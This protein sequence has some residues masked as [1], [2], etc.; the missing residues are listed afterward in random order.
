MLKGGDFESC[1][2]QF[3]LFQDHKG[4]WRCRGR[5]GNTE[6]P[7]VVKYPI[8]LQRTHPLTTF[9]VRQ[10]HARVCQNGTKETLAETRAKY[11]IPSGRRFVKKT[12][13]R[14][15]VCKRFQGLTFNNV[16]PPPLP[17][18][19]VKGA[20]AFSLTGVDFANLFMVQ[21]DQ[22]FQSRKVWMALITCY[23]TRGVH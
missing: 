6:A 14:C 15:V 4:V 21:I 11:W 2:K 12:V 5:L 17:E 3:G 8:L 16:P 10:A 1:K 9:I 13:H 19:W 7:Y 18:C 22:T 20:P 23:V